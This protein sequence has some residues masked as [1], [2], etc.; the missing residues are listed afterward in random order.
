MIIK[1]KPITILI[2]FISSLMF[3]G[4]KQEPFNIYQELKLTNSDIKKSKN[5]DFLK[6]VLVAKISYADDRLTPDLSDGQLFRDRNLTKFKITKFFKYSKNLTFEH[7]SSMFVDL[8]PSM[9]KYIENYFSEQKRLIQI[10]SC[11]TPILVIVQHRKQQKTRC[12]NGDDDMLPKGLL[13]PRLPDLSIGVDNPDV[14]G[15]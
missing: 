13:P 14:P 3:L 12:C 11:K 4:C 2:I 7:S 9:I 8:N 5:L 6:N 10:R 1:F 15:L